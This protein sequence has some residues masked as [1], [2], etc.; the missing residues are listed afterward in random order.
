MSLRGALAHLFPR[1]QLL[2]LNAVLWAE[3]LHF[4]LQFCDVC[5]KLLL[6]T[7]QLCSTSEHIAPAAAVTATAAHTYLCVCQ[8]RL[9]VRI[10]HSPGRLGSH[11]ATALPGVTLAPSG[12]T[13]TDHCPVHLPHTAV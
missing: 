3:S 5:I 10:S 7:S 8:R 6:C 2:Q 9:L 1:Q 13:A 4:L 12:A 11:R